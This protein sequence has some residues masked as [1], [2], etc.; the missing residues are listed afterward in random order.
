MQRIR[1]GI[2]GT[3]AVSGDFCEGL[4]H[5]SHSDLVA[6][7]S[8]TAANA[9]RFKV[10][11]GVERAC[12]FESLLGAKDLDIVYIATP[13]AQH[14]EHAIAC[15]NAGKAVLVE[16]PFAICA[17]DAREIAKVAREKNLFCMEAM[18]TRFVP[19]L[20]ELKETVKSGHLGAVKQMEASLGFPF[21][22][23]VHQR[24]FDPERAGGALLDLGVYPLSLVH[25]VL[26]KPVRVHSEVVMG[27][28]RVDEHS[29][30]TLTFPEG[31]QAVV[32]N[33]IRTTCRNDAFLQG[34]EASL[35]IDGPLYRPESFAVTRTPLLE[36]AGGAEK[37]SAL[38]RLKQQAALRAV[39]Q[40][41]KKVAV[42]RT[43]RLATGNGFAHEIIEANE[44][45][46]AGHKESRVLPLDESIAVL[47]TVDAIFES[48]KKGGP[49]EVRR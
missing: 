34:T 27:S 31:V 16:K 38:E 28:T 2:L 6:V 24:V 15:L 33:S 20:R 39:A 19:L 46:R 48:W 29:V 5:A 21:R 8:R 32:T 37:A 43:V 12:D 17:A 4:K 10:T 30:T 23:D 11:F 40:L 49:V 25:A 44:C 35:Q 9:E 22:V 42:P 36:S 18:W 7:A 45:L 13:H 3:G 1:W 41:A 26:G 47:E 14:K